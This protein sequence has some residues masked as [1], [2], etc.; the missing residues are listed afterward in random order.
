MKTE[1]RRNR[2]VGRSRWRQ[3]CSGALNVEFAILTPLLIG[4]VIAAIDASLFL[5]AKGIAEAGAYRAASYA[6]VVDGLDS[7][8]TMRTAKSYVENKAVEFPIQTL[9]DDN[10]LD[11]NA[12]CEALACITDVIVEVEPDPELSLTQNLA[13]LPLSVSIEFVYNSLVG[14]VIPFRQIQMTASVKTYREPRFATSLPISGD[15]NGIIGGPNENCPCPLDPGNSMKVL[16]PATGVCV[17]RDGLVTVPA[18]GEGD[19]DCEC[20]LQTQVW[21][22]V[23]LMCVCAPGPAGSV[24]VDADNCIY[25][26]EPGREIQ[27]G[28]CVCSPPTIENGDDC[29]CPPPPPGEPGCPLEQG[30]QRSPPDC[31]C[32]CPGEG[33]FCGGDCI[34]CDPWD[35]PHLNPDTCTCEHCAPDE[36]Y[37]GDHLECYANSPCHNGRGDIGYDSCDCNCFEEE[38]CSQG[39]VPACDTCGGFTRDWETCEC[40][41]GESGW[42]RCDN[43]DCVDADCS[44]RFDE[45]DFVIFDTA[46]CTCRCMDGYERVTDCTDGCE[47]WCEIGNCPPDSRP[48]GDRCLCNTMCE[49]PLTRPLSVVP[50]EDDCSCRCGDPD[51]SVCVSSGGTFNPETCDCSCPAEEGWFYQPSFY[52]H[53]AQCLYCGINRE[54]NPSVWLGCR[55]IPG[56]LGPCG[57]DIC[58]EPCE[59]DLIF[60]C[61][62]EIGEGICTCPEGQEV[63]NEGCYEPCTPPKDIRDPESC[64]CICPNQCTG[65]TLDDECNCNCSEGTIYCNDECHADCPIPSQSRFPPNCE[66]GCS[67]SQ[68]T[69]T[70]GSC[71]ELCVPPRWQFDP[72]DCACECPGSCGPHQI[73]DEGCNCICD[74]DSDFT[75]LCLGDCVGPCPVGLRRDPADNCDCNLCIEE[76]EECQGSCYA[77]PCSETH[78]PDHIR[79]PDSCACVC[80]AELPNEC[81]SGACHASCPEGQIFNPSECKCIC[82]GDQVM[83]NDQCHNPCWP[84]GEPGG[85]GLIRRPDL[86]CEC[87]CN[88]GGGYEECQDDCYLQCPAFQERDEIVYQDCDCHCV[89]GYSPCGASESFTCKPD[90][91]CIGGSWN[92]DCDTCV[93]PENYFLCLGECLDCPE[94][95]VPSAGDC[96]ICECPTSCG[97]AQQDPLT[98]ECG[99]CLPGS[100]RCGDEGPCFEI[101]CE[102]GDIPECAPNGT[103]TCIVPES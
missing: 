98:C 4:L 73:R 14:R 79:D 16:V 61:V 5:V 62:W 22:P 36:A 65:G 59:G 89:A 100:M 68:H 55:C 96:R 99:D 35:D 101:D 75:E 94:P 93:C 20:P 82:A 15:C 33:E 90:S 56:Y 32:I 31:E 84:V 52:H 102:P 78:T 9:F 39:C 25:E 53:P 29:I 88:I 64:E 70:D 1:E 21:D 91:Q 7:T 30:A 86:D 50:G 77:E 37:C 72:D 74:P 66:C 46:L 42:V 47:S 43:G 71:H 95:K 80:P 10:R 58:Y 44:S 85:E 49:S 2:G 3:R 24:L 17:C 38:E 6:S 27:E 12:E 19:F 18:G 69:C 8:T 34:T 54:P 67:G 97:W 63:C 23:A 81:N 76:E 48:S 41:E 28:E 83:C 26:C 51:G 45:L 92:Q 103:L 13:N 87:D 40:V 60:E 57:R 11:P